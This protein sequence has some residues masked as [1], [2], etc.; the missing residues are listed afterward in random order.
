MAE[1]TPSD[2]PTGVL[3]VT[4]RDKNAL[5]ASYMS[6]VK[7]GGLFIPTTRAVRLGDELILLLTLM[8]EVEK[9]PVAGK[10][11]WIT[12]R[13]SQNGKVAGVGVQFVEDESSR[14]ARNKIETYLA[15]ALTSERHT[16]TM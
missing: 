4:I 10:V 2:T 16:H 11:I 7:G 5:Y 12:P 8:D 13:G 14:V 15:G 6:F 3:A 9:I 1:H